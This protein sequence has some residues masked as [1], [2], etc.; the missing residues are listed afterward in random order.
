MKRRNECIVCGRIFYE[1]QG[2]K[3][4]VKGRDYLF[5]SKACAYKF[6]KEAIYDMDADQVV[7]AFKTIE[8]KYSEIL[9]KFK[10]KKKKVI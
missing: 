10:E 6:L 5:H 8:K 4:T 2:I 7:E 1:G 9:E 3:I